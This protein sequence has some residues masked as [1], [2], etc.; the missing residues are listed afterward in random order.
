V[1][2]GSGVPYADS[3]PSLLGARLASRGVQVVPAAMGGWNTVQ[4]L[5]CLRRNVD[6]LAP[7]VVALLY[8]MNDAD[9]VDPRDAAQRTPA[10]PWGRL[11]RA[12]VVHSRLFERGAWV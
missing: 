8:V 7:D 3:Y 1:T 2:A 11:Y 10:S 5:H 12:L 4:E 6:R 9:H